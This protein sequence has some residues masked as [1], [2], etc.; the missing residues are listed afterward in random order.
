MSDDKRSPS[1]ADELA[2][3]AMAEFSHERSLVQERSEEEAKRKPGSG[4]YAVLAVVLLLFATLIGLNLSGRLP[5]QVATTP[6]SEDEVRQNLRVALNYAVRQI[7]SSRIAN[8]RYPATLAEVGGPDHAGW[9]FVRV[10]EDQ[11][12]IALSEGSVSVEYDSSQDADTF[13]ADVRQQ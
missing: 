2:A 4:Q 7:E 5:F 1:K 6:V 3:E 9:T 11:Y 13:F 8:G 12:R 10:G